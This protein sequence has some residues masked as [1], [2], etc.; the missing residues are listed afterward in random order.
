[1]RQAIHS[2][3]AGPEALSQ[4]FSWYLVQN[5]CFLW[6]PQVSAALNQQQSFSGSSSGCGS[7]LFSSHTRGL[8]APLQPRLQQQQPFLSCQPGTGLLCPFRPQQQQQLLQPQF[9]S[10]IRHFVM[11]P[12]RVK[13]RKAHK[14]QGFNE[15]ICPNTRQLAFG[16]YGVR[17]MEHCR[18]PA[19]TIEA[20]RYACIHCQRLAMLLCF[21]RI[22]RRLPPVRQIVVEL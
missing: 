4:S 10:S 18:M 22:M 3:P 13:Y 16:L 7:R 19:K 1:M 11:Q 17:A 2:S 9:G 21:P 8:H 14:S 15:T 12:R 6:A 5:S 20:A